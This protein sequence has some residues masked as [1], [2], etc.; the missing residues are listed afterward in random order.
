M[1]HC[2]SVLIIIFTVAF[3]GCSNLLPF[4]SSSV[5]RGAKWP[6][7]LT[8]DCLDSTLRS[9]GLLSSPVLDGGVSRGHTRTHLVN[10]RCFNTREAHYR[11][12]IEL[13]LLISEFPHF[14][15][16]SAN[17]LI[18]FLTLNFLLTLNI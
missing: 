9:A 13:I 18:V 1:Y 10:R 7:Q 8:G 2:C 14:P 12:Y 4:A 16:L 6:Y 5:S 3:F 15:T 11:A 17:Q